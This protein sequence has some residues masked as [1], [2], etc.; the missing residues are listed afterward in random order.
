M[1]KQILL[2]CA[3][4]LHAAGVEAQ[5]YC[6]NCDTMTYHN[7][8]WQLE[9]CYPLDQSAN[10][11]SMKGNDG[12]EFGT[13]DA[14]GRKNQPLTAYHFDGNTDYVL[15]N[16]LFDYNQ[17]TISVWF[18]V[19]S[20]D[21]NYQDIY[22]SDDPSVA[23]GL[24]ALAVF[25]D[26]VTKLVYVVGSGATVSV[27]I[28]LNTWYHA[29]IV[30]ND[31]FA[32]YYL[33]CSNVG[34]GL[35]NFHKSSNGVGQAVLGGS[36]DTSTYWFSGSIDDVRIYSTNLNEDA[37][38]SLC[39]LNCCFS[40]DTSLTIN[41]NLEGCYPFTN[42]AQ[43]E[44]DNHFDGNVN[45][46][47]RDFDRYGNFNESYYFDGSSDYIALPSLFDYED[48]TYSLWFNATNISSVQN[49]IVSD[50]PSLINGLTAMAVRN[51]GGPEVYFVV[52]SGATVSYSINP[53]QWYHAVIVVDSNL[54]RYYVDG[55]LIGSG[56][57]NYHKSSNG[58]GQTVVGGA[59]DLTTYWFEG[60]VDD[61]K[62]YSKALDSATI[63]HLYLD[64]CC[65]D[66]CDTSGME[67]KNMTGL[68][69][70]FSQPLK[71]YP[72]PGKGSFR[73][74][75][76]AVESFNVVIY[77]V[78]GREVYQRNS[79]MSDEQLSIDAK[80]GVYFIKVITSS[81]KI[82]TTRYQVQY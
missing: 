8:T 37:L 3:L 5:N 42:E 1:K 2:F 19:D 76:D 74:S 20:A 73:I 11:V 25:K 53:N 36:R 51:S 17:R 58:V 27:P 79:I 14:D 48:R 61:I 64:S 21:E 39:N 69:E 15:L 24:T 63:S 60:Y 52:G 22:V 55:V 40:C 44:T 41:A 71:V 30:V 68:K 18:K 9:A 62:I 28:S 43:D 12:T 26:S 57:N 80:P 38:D 67:L 49:I 66:G 46:A 6:L 75:I 16:Q 4:L 78:N 10:D 45:D 29:S 70:K 31:S 72:N 82:L 56:L 35:N 23:N 34:S 81:G 13:T 77:D 59:R 50:D 33:D 65:W 7:S 54:A 47:T 32:Y